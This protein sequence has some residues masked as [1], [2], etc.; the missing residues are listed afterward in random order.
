MIKARGT[1]EPRYQGSR[2]PIPLQEEWRIAA[3]ITWFL[4]RVGVKAPCGR[5]HNISNEP[6]PTGRLGID[7]T[8]GHQDLGGSANLMAAAFATLAYAQPMRLGCGQA[9]E[10]RPSRHHGRGGNMAHGCLTCEADHHARFAIRQADRRTGSR[11]RESG[12]GGR[13]R[14]GSSAIVQQSRRSRHDS[15]E[16]A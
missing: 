10:A 5:V 7:A 13:E 4:E 16:G 8:W 9:L 3:L 11:I 14:R 1:W 2:V 15:W 12:H 6:S